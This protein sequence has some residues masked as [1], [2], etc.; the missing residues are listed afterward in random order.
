MTLLLEY[1]FKI[2]VRNK[3]NY[4]IIVKEIVQHKYT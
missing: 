2:S 3:E 4:H 1:C